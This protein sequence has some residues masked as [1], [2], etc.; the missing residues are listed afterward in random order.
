MRA[1]LGLVENWIKIEMFAISAV[2]HD[3][4][5]LPREVRMQRRG[6]RRLATRRLGICRSRGFVLLLLGAAAWVAAWPAPAR[7]QQSAPAAS[8][9]AAAPAK[10][11]PK[12]ATKPETKPEAAKPA[13]PSAAKPASPAS[14][15]AAG[16]QP[17]LLGQYRMWGAYPAATRG[18]K[19][20]F[21]RA[22]RSTAAYI[23]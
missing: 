8:P 21:P 13:A 1:T 14:A 20:V 22:K 4:G 19:A 7:A 9:P 17:K 16:V 15:A 18:E 23:P 2:R 6:M 3:L 10:P 12:P 5:A 11:K